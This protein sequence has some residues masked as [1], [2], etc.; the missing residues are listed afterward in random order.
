MLT[1]VVLIVSAKFNRISRTRCERN[2]TRKCEYRINIHSNSHCQGSRI[3]VFKQH[4]SR[5][6]SPFEVD[7]T[8][9]STS[10]LSR[11]QT[12]WLTALALHTQEINRVLINI[13]QEF[14]ANISYQYLSNTIFVVSC[15]QTLSSYYYELHIAM[16]IVFV[17]YDL[18]NT[19][20]LMELV[21]FVHRVCVLSL[22]IVCVCL[23]SLVDRVIEIVH[24]IAYVAIFG[25]RMGL[26]ELFDVVIDV[27]SL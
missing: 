16:V 20:V 3:Q 13:V 9:Y 12:F 19:V 18:G 5:V 24:S 10:I 22:C 21:W 23:L 8:L 7:Y 15:T 17:H 25:P 11:T 6:S 27:D 2:W 14:S 26:C 1:F 4:I